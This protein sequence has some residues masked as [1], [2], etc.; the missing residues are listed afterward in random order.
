MTSN[1]QSQPSS[2]NKK[3]KHH[4]IKTFLEREGLTTMENGNIYYPFQV[5]V[6]SVVQI[7]GHFLLKKR[8]NQYWN[9]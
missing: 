1:K 7:K 5:G 8:V 3:Y 2:A 4:R 6:S 9:T